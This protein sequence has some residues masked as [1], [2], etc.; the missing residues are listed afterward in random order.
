ML[1]LAVTL[2]AVA[3]GPLILVIMSLA[4]VLGAGIPFLIWLRTM[5]LP[6]AFLVTSVPFLALSVDF[7][8]GF[9]IAFSPQGLQTAVYVMVRSLAAVSCLLF[10]TLTTP[11]IDLLP[12]LR[13]L[14]VPQAVVEIALLIYRL[15]FVF[16][17][18]AAAGRQAQVARQGYT[19]FRNS[20]HSLGLLVTNLFQHSLIQAQRMETGLAARGF[21]GEL[22]VLTPQRTLS[23]S[24][25]AIIISLL[26]GVAVTGLFLDRV[27]P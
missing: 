7:S 5:A 20:L 15:V 19:S 24:R 21:Q 11:A 2:P 1:L 10:L 26:M 23:R 16:I 14:G 4:I 17:E 8:S 6:G 3:T 9:G 18:R 27:L 13:R 12:L 25:L 22:R